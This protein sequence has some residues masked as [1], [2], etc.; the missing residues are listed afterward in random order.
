MN[1]NDGIRVNVKHIAEEGLSITGNLPPSIFGIGENDRLNSPNPLAYELIAF[2]TAH[3][4]LV[5]G[6]LRTTLRCRCDRCL[7]YYDHPVENSDVCLF[8]EEVTD[9]FLDLTEDVRE[10]ILLGFPQKCLCI[11]DCRG[12]CPECG[13][14][15][16]VRE[17]DCPAPASAPSAFDKLDRLDL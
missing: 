5:R 10:D 16:N 14:N 12:L 9:D 15:L 8:Y 1:K 11:P 2:P 7:R 3:D 4:I 13:H 6:T 17:C